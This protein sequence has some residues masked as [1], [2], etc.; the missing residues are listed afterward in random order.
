TGVQIQ[1][2]HA[3]GPTLFPILTVPWWPSP[4]FTTNQQSFPP[5]APPTSVTQ[6]SVS[7][8]KNSNSGLLNTDSN[9]ASSAVG[10][11]SVPSGAAAAIFYDS[12][13]H[14]LQPCQKIKALE[15]QLDYNSSCHV[16]QYSIL[17]YPE[18]KPRET[19]L[20]I[21]PDVVVQMRDELK[22]NAIPIH[23]WDV[24]CI[25]GSILDRQ[26]AAEVNTDIPDSVVTRDTAE[27]VTGKPHDMLHWCLPKA[28]VQISAGKMPIWQNP[29]S[30]TEDDTG[31]E[32][33]IKKLSV[34]EIEISQRDILPIFGPLCRI[35]PNWSDSGYANSEPDVKNKDP[36][37]TAVKGVCSVNIPSSLR[38]VPCSAERILAKEDESSDGV[39][40]SDIS[41]SSSSGST[42]DASNARASRFESSL[43]NIDDGL[44]NEHFQDQL[45][46]GKYFQEGYGKASALEDI[47]SSD[48]ILGD[49]DLDCCGCRSAE[50]QLA[51]METVFLKSGQ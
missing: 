38:H 6:S 12:I 15:H 41:N 33:E 24:K 51:F 31:G 7:R 44:I 32:I 20:G 11:V 5:S 49:V 21:G 8:I 4:S 36:E 19:S 18:L 2:S 17:P 1:N 13:S 30:F 27:K 26:E 3:D 39:G 35:Q 43:N 22:V 42:S 45:D 48:E 14:N 28:E 50:N 23:W 47:F 10:N 16:I 9:V 46:Y 25:F 37:T 40:T 29:K 34:K